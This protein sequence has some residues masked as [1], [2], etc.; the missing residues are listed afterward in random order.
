VWDGPPEVPHLVFIP[1]WVSHKV[2]KV[3]AGTRVVGKA[4]VYGRQLTE[5]RGE[6]E[7]EGSSE[8]GDDANERFLFSL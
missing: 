5:T 7:E 8:D 1:L 2:T 6:E 3:T 4:S